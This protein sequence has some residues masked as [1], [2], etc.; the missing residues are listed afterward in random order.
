MVLIKASSFSCHGDAD[1]ELA[2][3]YTQNLSPNLFGHVCAWDESRRCDM[4]W[5]PR[6]G[7]PGSLWMITLRNRLPLLPAL[8]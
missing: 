3:L 1:Y 2:A 8:V 6:Y 5:I 4:K 7:A